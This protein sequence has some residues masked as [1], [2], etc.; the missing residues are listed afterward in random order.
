MACHFPLRNSFI[1][2]YIGQAIAKGQAT[3]LQS[4][5][6]RAMPRHGMVKFPNPDQ[7]RYKG[8]ILGINQADKSPILRLSG[9]PTRKKSE[10]LYPPGLFDLRF[11]HAVSPTIPRSESAK[12]P[13]HPRLGGVPLIYCATR[14]SCAA[15]QSHEPIAGEIRPLLRP[16]CR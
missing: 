5:S 10:K 8:H 3:N 14:R 9:T 13:G 1:C 11:F 16:A 2:A 6:P 4:L 12:Q 7:P 15:H